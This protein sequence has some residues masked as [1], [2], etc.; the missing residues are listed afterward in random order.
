MTPWCTLSPLNITVEGDAAIAE[1][2]W[3]TDGSGQHCTT[4]REAALKVVSLT[5][6]GVLFQG[7]DFYSFGPANLSVDGHT[8][9]G[10]VSD[11]HGEVAGNFSVIKGGQPVQKICNKHPPKP[12]PPPPP[13]PY[14]RR[15]ETSPWPHP[16]NYS[17]GFRTVFH[18]RDFNFTV[19]NPVGAGPQAALLH[20]AAARYSSSIS[21]ARGD[22]CNA[23]IADKTTAPLLRCSV[24]VQDVLVALGEGVDESYKLNLSIDGACT[25]VA[26]TVW[27]ALHGMES[28]AQLGGENCTVVNAPVTIDDRPRFAYRGLMIDTARAFLN[29]AFIRHIIDGMVA[30]RLNVLHMHL[31]DA[32]SFPY[33]S[34]RFPALSAK[35][36]FSPRAT[37]SPDALRELVTYGRDRGVRLVPEYDVP[38]HGGTTWAAATP[39]IVTMDAKGCGPGTGVSY[40]LNPTVDATYAFLTEFLSEVTTVF[41]DE[42]L[43][44]GGDEVP[45]QC[46]ESSPS[47]SAWMRAHHMN[48]TDLQR[49]FWQQLTARVFPLL[50]RTIGVWDNNSPPLHPEDLPQQRAFANVWGT[51]AD[52]RAVAA[53]QFPVVFSGA[54]YLDQRTPGACQTEFT[55]S[56]DDMWKCFYDVEPLEG[57]TDAQAQYVLGGQACQWSLGAAAFDSRVWTNT[58]AMAERLWSPRSMN[59]SVATQGTQSRLRDHICRLNARGFAANTISPGLCPMFDFA[60]Q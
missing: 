36:A 37:Y 33:V 45:T 13:N 16:R 23:S 26:P 48:A 3:E 53:V 10:I 50:N 5:G 12:P 19:V 55:Y 38:G 59:S 52:L 40:P 11:K 49:Y 9:S 25:L 32:E 18:L 56:L 4:D 21:A 42:Y 41:S 34:R 2:V 44:L 27:G 28:L 20:R 31:V 57:L 8:L 24:A 43:F 30:N 58:A 39:E 51:K 29:V 6:G 15:W 17:A 7:A 54:W 46:W 47:V 60:F 35:G 22:G 14:I 1:W